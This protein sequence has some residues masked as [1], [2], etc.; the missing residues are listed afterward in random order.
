MRSSHLAP[1][2]LLKL[3]RL[4]SGRRIVLP[5]VIYVMLLTAIRNTVVARLLGPEQFGLAVTFLLAQQLID[6]TTDTGLNKFVLQSKIGN[7]PST[8][9]MVQAIAVARGLIIAVALIA[10]AWPVFVTL[11]FASS[12]TPFLMLAAM[13]VST[14]LLHYDNARQQRNGIF[15]NDSLSSVIG[16]TC[17]FIAAIMVLIW[18]RSYIVAV[19]AIM[20]RAIATTA[21]SHLLAQRRYTIRYAATLAPTVFAFSWPLLINGPLLF[22]SSQADRLLVNAV[23]GLRELGI[24][25]ATLLLLYLPLGLLTRVVGTIFVPRLSAA[26]REGEIEDLET[27]FSGTVLTLAI[28]AACGFTAVGPGILVLLYG[29]AYALHVLPIALIA[30][31]QSMRFLR[32][33]PS[34]LSIAL[35]HTGNLLFSNILRLLALPL[36]LAGILLDQGIPGLAA[37]LLLGE[38]LAL[39][40]SLLMLNR[41]RRLPLGHGL[42]IASMALGVATTL[43]LMLWWFDPGPLAAAGMALATLVAA[44][45]LTHLIDR[46]LL[47][48]DLSA[49]GW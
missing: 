45:G 29:P 17:G 14:G 6:S 38:A 44:L 21:A 23:L 28:L 32:S 46:R 30:L 41:K 39:V 12:I 26:N 10:L 5:A 4:L 47:P 3:K 1:R 36:G 37:G 35:G 43:P 42:P 27:Q 40:L 19:I 9:A 2:F 7:R 8:Q 33:W 25:S 48:R 16:E 13:A 49:F 18:T 22:L 15:A 24:Y 34:S 11:G 20:V 31:M